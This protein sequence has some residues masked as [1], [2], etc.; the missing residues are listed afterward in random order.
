MASSRALCPHNC[1]CSCHDPISSIEGVL[2]IG[3]AFAWGP[4]SHECGIV[5]LPPPPA[6]PR[7]PTA[8]MGR[9]RLNLAATLP[10]IVLNRIFAFLD[11]TRDIVAWWT[12]RAPRRSADS[13]RLVCVQ[14]RRAFNEQLAASHASLVPLRWEAVA[15]LLSRHSLDVRGRASHRRELLHLCVGTFRDVRC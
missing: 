2:P 14:W 9:N 3:I 7:A 4:R 5:L 8:P 11:C 10:C 1:W 6:V 13:V 12:P 15:E